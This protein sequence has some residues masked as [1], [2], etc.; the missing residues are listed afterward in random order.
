MHEIEKENNLKIKNKNVNMG[1]IA[2]KSRDK[3]EL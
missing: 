2:E 3:R 1:K